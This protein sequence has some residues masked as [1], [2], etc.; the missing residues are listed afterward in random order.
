M[1]FLAPAILTSK[2]LR[3][4]LLKEEVLINQFNAIKSARVIVLEW[5]TRP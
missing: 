3:D 4:E 1:N 2:Q 5:R